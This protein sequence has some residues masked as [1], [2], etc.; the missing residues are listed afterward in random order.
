MTETAK[1]FPGWTEWVA[2]KSL[3]G[4][5]LRGADR[6]NQ[7]AYFLLLHAATEALFRQILFIGFRLNKVTYEAAT[8]WLLH[9]DKTPDLKHYPILFDR[10]YLGKA[11]SWEELGSRNLKL[12]QALGLWHEFSKVVRNHIS[13]GIRKYK[14]EWIACAILI[15][16]AVLMHLDAAINPVI[17]GSP[18]ESLTKLSPRLPHGRAETDLVALTGIKQ[19]LKQ[20]PRVSLIKAEALVGQ[21]IGPQAQ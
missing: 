11:V 19:K 8:E 10:L 20:R 12:E 7:E 15:D 3:V 14:E 5:K 4:T 2:A 13:H 21:I 18:L 1:D 17:G 6:N 9:N 16:Q